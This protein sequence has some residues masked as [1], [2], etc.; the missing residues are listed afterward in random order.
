MRKAL[1]TLFTFFTLLTPL[2][3]LPPHKFTQYTSEDG[4][5]EYVVQCIMQ[6]HQGLMWF[7]TWD[8]LYNFD[9]FKFRRLGAGANGVKPTNNRLDQLDED[10]YGYLWM[11]SYDGIAYR[12]D[13][14]SAEYEQVTNETHQVKTLKLM[15]DGTAWLITQQQELLMAR[16][17]TVSQTVTVSD[18]F[19][20]HALNKPTRI[21]SLAIDN[22]HRHWILTEEGAYRFDPSTDKVSIISTRPCYELLQID[23]TFYIGS[24]RGVVLSLPE[25]SREPNS[26]QLDTRSSIKLLR[27]HPSGC[28]VA[29]TA[30]DGFFLLPQTF[31]NPSEPLSFPRTRPTGATPQN[32][33]TLHITT[34]NCKAL[35]SNSLH[36]IYID[37]LGQ[38][39]IRTYQTGVVHYDPATDVARHFILHDVYGKPIVDSRGDLMAV[40]DVD[41]QLWIHPSG[42][43]LAWYDR[44]NDQLVP[45]YNP[46]LQN[47][48]SN[49]NK[50]TALF[51]DNQGN[52]WFGSYGNGLEKASFGQYPFV[53][54]SYDREALDFAGNNIRAIMQD[55]D[56]YIWAGGKDRV[57]RVYDADYR[58]VGNLC[59][60]GKV[61]PDKEEDLG[62][63]YGFMQSRDGTL[64]IGTKGDGLYMLT[65]KPSNPSNLSNL[66]NLSL[67]LD[68]TN[69]SNPSNPSNPST[70]S[71]LS[72]LLRQFKSSDDNI[73]SLSSNEIYSL[74]EAQN[75][76]IWLATFQNGVNIMQRDA[77]GMPTRFYSTRNQLTSYPLISCYRARFISGDRRGNI[78]IGTTGG[79][80]TCP[81]NYTSPDK[82]SFRRYHH[83]KADPTTLPSDDVH[84]IFFTDDGRSFVCSFGGG[85]S[86]MK[87]AS[88]GTA[89]F[90]RLGFLPDV[91]NGNNQDQG[92][93]GDVILS[94]QQ[95]S[96]GHL[97]CAT[98]DGLLSYDLSTGRISNFRTRLF[99]LHFTINE[100]QAIALHNGELMFNTTRGLL[101]FHPT[102]LSINRYA[103]PIHFTTDSILL[104]PGQRSFVAQFAALDYVSPEV[105]TYA[106]RLKGFERDWTYVG[107]GHTATY[108]NLSPGDY[109]LEVRS[110]NSG[111]FWVDNVRSL[112]V[113]VLPTFGETTLA[114]VLRV[115]AV[116][117]LLA[118]IIGIAIVIYRLKHR[119]KVEE[120][121]TNMK[122]KFFTNVSHEL[123]TPLTLITGPLEHILQ[124][125]DLTPELSEQLGIVSSNATKM[126][127]LVSQI[128]DFRKIQNGKMT[129]S[130]ENF[131]FV[132]FVA[133]QVDDFKLLAQTMQIDLIYEHKVDTLPLWADP[134]KL[135]QV[136]NNL[137]SNA[138][139]Y[140]H[141]GHPIRV[142]V[143]EAKGKAILS[144]RDYGV[145]ITREGLLHLYERFGNRLSHSP[146]GMESTGIGLSL[147]KELV[148]LHHGQ[149][150]VHSQ[151]NVGTCFTVY[152]PLGREHF[153][154]DTEFIVSDDLSP[155][156]SEVVPP[157]VE[158]DAT[159]TDTSLLIVEDNDELRRF[160]RQIFATRYK[161][162]EAADG[163][164]GLNKASNLMPDIVISDVMMPG[165]DGFGMARQMRESQELCHIPLIL[166]TALADTD[167]KLEGLR[168]GIDD[169]ITKPFS[170]SYL[171]ARVDNILQK[172]RLLQQYY[173][174]Q[175]SAAV[176]PHYT[177][178][179]DNEQNEPLPS[180]AAALLSP[181]DQHFIDIVT[182]DL[183][184]NLSNAD[185]S[186]DD[187]A[188]VTN[189]SRSSYSKKLKAIIGQTPSDLLRDAR[190]KR[191]A[192]LIDDGQLNVAEVAYEVGYNDPHYFGKA[193]KA[194]YQMTPTE[195]RNRKNLDQP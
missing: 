81:E 40:E 141:T 19:S 122:L 152:L 138:F 24:N 14:R 57:I 117:T 185:Y 106:Y 113:V 130:V 69:G 28:L 142:T 11:V 155:T 153:T 8:G 110:T 21:N 39:W 127:Q 146:S 94:M 182:A 2:L 42:G 47:R 1:F 3:A 23:D 65:P 91:T 31:Q 6:D 184:H 95:D 86:E 22:R 191:A 82:I 77:Q 60:D 41:G 131:D 148:D 126:S 15:E 51:S 123:R 16:H 192:E 43:G 78:W 140:S 174:H 92:E 124:R 32:P 167:N 61:R 135:A 164:D 89:T 38:L 132:P 157:P 190:M 25:G 50:L 139:K 114:T 12:F 145:G 93:T 44:D 179:R 159:D 154:P 103:P 170:A 160:I 33:S 171:T 4:L 186:V 158:T 175:L 115:L 53:I 168:S 112:P 49:A 30:S 63:A 7:A 161:V 79:L 189:M 34:A 71:P 101:H 18:F 134:D 143:E 187:M 173:L 58:F 74:Y 90:H 9:G 73:Y 104:Q 128:L 121:L 84:G 116:L 98:E 177:A 147:T 180:P 119:V 129:L 136:V 36:D 178:M 72:F 45:F 55:R 176:A 70:P 26:H 120:E 76:Q 64:W 151:P 111:G 96:I 172:R 80:L 97:W 46:N 48:W 59:H 20:T 166:L 67:P 183:Q 133:R 35:G 85:L 62:Q 29:C 87:L 194:Y 150:T 163:L 169:Y 99:P 88:D 195:W 109:Q 102:R 107:T 149:I 125:H 68:A 137:L 17:D 13:P 188:R 54:E 83:D 75:G 105:I 156:R 52:L 66:S 165:L 144:V 108:T 10:R 5:E 162:Y 27:S 118:L 181:A 37:R 56:G 193:F 100:G